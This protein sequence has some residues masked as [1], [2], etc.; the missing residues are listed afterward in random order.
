[1]PLAAPVT[2][3]V[4][5]LASSLDQL[6]GHAVGVAGVEAAHALPGA[7]LGDRRPARCG[8]PRRPRAGARGRR[9]CRRRA[10]RCASR[11][12]SFGLGA[13]RRP[14]RRRGTRSARAPGRA[15]SSRSA[16]RAAGVRDAGDLEL[17]GPEAVAAR[18]QLAGRA[19]RGRTRAS[20]RGRRWSPRRGRGRRAP[21]PAV[22]AR[23]R[24]Q[25]LRDQRRGRRRRRSSRG[26]GSS[27]PR[28]PRR[29]RVPGRGEGVEVASRPRPGRRRCRGTRARRPARPSGSSGVGHDHVERAGAA[30]DVGHRRRRRVGVRRRRGRS[31]G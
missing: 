1:M 3:T 6:H 7:R 31:S 25:P 20:G 11:P 14:A 22:A 17:V 4:R 13:G 12:G 24:P 2:Q 18:A 15:A 28:R 26:G 29:A 19:G 10:A 27:P 21:R 16:Q 9:R 5:G 23:V 8:P 30:G